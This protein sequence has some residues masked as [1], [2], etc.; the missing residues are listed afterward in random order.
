MSSADGNGRFGPGAISAAQKALGGGGGVP[1]PPPKPGAMLASSLAAQS[2][3]QE[4]AAPAPLPPPAPP[5]PLSDEAVLARIARAGLRQFKR[6]YPAGGAVHTPTGDATTHKLF[7]KNTQGQKVDY[8][9]TDSDAYPS[10]VEPKKYADIASQITPTAASAVLGKTPLSAEESVSA[11]RAATT[12]MALAKVSETQRNG[13]G[14]LARGALDAIASGD[15]PAEV[16]TGDAPGFP[17]SKPGGMQYHRDVMSGA[18]PVTAALRNVVGHM[19]DSS[20]D[21]EVAGLSH[22]EAVHRYRLHTETNSVRGT[23]VAPAG[24]AAGVGAAPA[25]AEASPRPRSDSVSSSASSDD[26]DAAPPL[27]S[28]RVSRAGS[29]AE[30]ELDPKRHRPQGL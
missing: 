4:L 21:E 10:S 28:K 14:K 20:D 8:V 16:Y 11:R 22:G 27:R 18:S 15:S 23:L 7:E 6:D 3:A 2:V 25:Q 12:A 5:A 24:A 30:L 29:G 17:Q 19:S 26:E 9:R 1:G 13:S